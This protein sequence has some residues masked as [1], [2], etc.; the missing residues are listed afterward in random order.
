MS[1]AKQATAVE[2]VPFEMPDDYQ[3][4]T[5]MEGDQLWWKPAEGAVVHG[6]ILG[7]FERKGGDGGAFYQIKVEKLKGR[8]TLVKAISGKGDEAKTIDVTPGQVINV[9]ERSAIANLAPLA[10]SDGVFNMLLHCHGKVKI[11]GGKTFWRM[12]CGSKVIKPPSI[13]LS[14]SRSQTSRDDMGASY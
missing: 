2:E 13:P 9:D 10:E 14:L 1:K 3:L 4:V 11:S 5:P 7:R 12:S 8:D 6:R